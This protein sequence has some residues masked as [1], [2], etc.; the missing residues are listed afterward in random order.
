MDQHSRRTRATWMTRKLKLLPGGP[1]AKGQR[2]NRMIE[3]E[4]SD[5]RAKRAPIHANEWNEREGRGT[6]EQG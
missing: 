3:Q 1:R 6:V 4:D 2:I 5:H